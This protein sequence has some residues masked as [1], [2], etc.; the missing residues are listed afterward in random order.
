MTSV[1][2]GNNFLAISSRKPLTV[3]TPTDKQITY[4]FITYPVSTVLALLHKVIL[5]QNARS[6]L[7]QIVKHKIKVVIVPF[8]YVTRIMPFSQFLK[9]HSSQIESSLVLCEVIG[10]IFVTLHKLVHCHAKVH[11]VTIY[12]T[13]DNVEVYLNNLTSVKDCMHA[14]APIVNE[15]KSEI[16]SA[17]STFM[18]HRLSVWQCL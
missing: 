12:T 14:Q 1:R 17:N 8:I 2:K 6:S 11:S 15:F 4:S 13:Q 10:D 18:F 3:S 9:C 16:F 7:Q 5:F